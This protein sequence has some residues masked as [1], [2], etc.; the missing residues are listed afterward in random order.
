MAP[1]S[2]AGLGHRYPSLRH[3]DLVPDFARRVARSLG[4]QFAVGL[5]KA[6]ETAE[7]KTRENSAQQAANVHGAFEVAGSLARGPVLLIDDVVDSRWT[8]TECARV[9]RAAGVG[10][11][12]PVAL[13]LAS[14]SWRDAS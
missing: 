8:F 3:P 10:A 9:L 7:Q 13:A 6:R 1:G 11:V 4:L 2:H 12:F 14:P 5:V